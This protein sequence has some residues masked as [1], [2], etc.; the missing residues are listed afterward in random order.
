M[1]NS[2]H[3]YEP[4][5]HI[6]KTVTLA[7]GE[8]EDRPI[9]M[10]RFAQKILEMLFCLQNCSEKNV[11]VIEKIFLK[12]EAQVKKFFWITKWNGTVYSNIKSQYNF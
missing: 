11:L 12:I 1:L 6:M 7:N 5:L 10:V 3:K 9:K 4:R 8:T 2:L